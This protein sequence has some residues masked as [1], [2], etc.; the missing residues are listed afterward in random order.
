[1]STSPQARVL[2]ICAEALAA[3]DGRALGPAAI[4]ALEGL[5]TQQVGGPELEPTVMALAAVA[6]D[7]SRRP[8]AAEAAQALL[9]VA[10][11]AVPD[12]RR[13]KN[14]FDRS[15]EAAA[16]ARGARLLGAPKPQLLANRPAQGR[17]FWELFTKEVP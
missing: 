3:G 8:G 7:L 15:R 4:V 14:L 2:R 17:R 16:R 12:L 13:R 11:R 5:L 9:A 10:R 6:C 1:M